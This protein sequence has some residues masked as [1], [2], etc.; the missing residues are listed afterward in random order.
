MDIL[1]YLSELIQT[2]KSVGI[3][4]LGTVYKKKSPG[5]YDAET[6]SFIP[7]S[8]TLDFTP[9]V[10]EEVLLAAY[11]SKS[12]NV[13]VDTATYFINDFS[14]AV[15]QQLNDHQQAS[16]GTLGKLFR[17]DDQLRFEPADKLN[18]GFDFFGLPTVKA[19]REDVAQEIILETP[20]VEEPEQRLSSGYEIEEVQEEPATEESTKNIQEAESLAAQ[21]AAA[22]IGSADQ[23]SDTWNETN[24]VTPESVS[25]AETLPVAQEPLLP[26]T[27]VHPVQETIP[28]QEKDP[29]KDEQQ[30]RAE[31]EALNFYR[32]NSP[33]T[34]TTVHESEEVIWHIKDTLPAMAT[35][36]AT[37]PADSVYEPQEEEVK[38]RS[39][40]LTIII[41]VFILALIVVG[42]Y[43]LKPELFS[44]FIGKTPVS[45]SKTIA[46]AIQPV[47]TDSLTS[48]STPKQDSL[49]KP[50]AT[51]SAA[52][53][54]AKTVAV[55][56]IVPVQVK[57]TVITYEIIGASM[58]D[59]KEADNFIAQMKKS[60]IEAK[61]VTNMAGKRLKMSIATLKD[62]KSAQLELD[63]L[64]KKLKI[65]GIY[66][67]RNKQ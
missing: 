8:F 37:L 46:P 27:P 40:L 50:A 18:Y 29:K 59:Q 41:V 35:P 6:H 30:L 36:P 13:S 5:R 24:N 57:D 23:A 62:E 22:T 34:K 53:D 16:L 20:N 64:S 55:K 9:E 21:E 65:P 54:S 28:V 43:L 2:R 60:G 51:K 32:S 49:K 31:I 42:T 12:R 61:V 56:P 1:S 58:H 52:K 47:V 14:S 11:I 15:L 33:V 48:S 45:S 66:I 26:E 10:K 7:P 19:E 63:R 25:S 39:P 4:G 38:K 44:Q 17:T 67:Y 3:L